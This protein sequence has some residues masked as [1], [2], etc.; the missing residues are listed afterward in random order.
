MAFLPGFFNEGDPSIAAGH[1]TDASNKSSHNQPPHVVYG[2]RN[3]S[4]NIGRDAVIPPIAVLPGQKDNSITN[5]EQQ[6]D[7][8][9]IDLAT[10][11]R[12]NSIKDNYTTNNF[13]ATGKEPQKEAAQADGSWGL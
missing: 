8:K 10:D 2:G 6:G 9:K 5:H 1:L 13:F 7:R 4:S 3:S 11:P 12:G